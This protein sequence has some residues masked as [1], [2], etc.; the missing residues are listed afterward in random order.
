MNKNIV[1]FTMDNC[2]HCVSLKKKLNELKILFN[3]IEINHNKQIWDQVVQQT[4]HNVVPTIFIRRENT[5]DGEVYIPGK[6]F[7]SRDEAIKIIKKNI[8]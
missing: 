6:D 7:N 4:G 3:E 2:G 8:L 1:L 5:D